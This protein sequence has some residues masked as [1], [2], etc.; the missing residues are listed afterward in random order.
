MD[1][2]SVSLS[3]ASSMD[4]QGVSLSTAGSM[5]VQGV[6]LSTTISMDVQGVCIPFHLCRMFLICRNAGLT[7]IRSVRCRNEKKILLT[8]PVLC[9]IR[10]SSPV[11]E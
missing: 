4:V 3:A 8:E 2:Q 11:Q 1:V 7:G 5:D 9:Q 6:S 10:G